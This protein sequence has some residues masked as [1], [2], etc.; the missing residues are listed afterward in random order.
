MKMINQLDQLGLCFGS[1]LD[2]AVFIF[3][4]RTTY[5]F[6]AVRICTFCLVK[7]QNYFILFIC[8]HLDRNKGKRCPAWT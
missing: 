3:F 8:H 6:T 2:Q 4:S 1:W 5:A 7:T